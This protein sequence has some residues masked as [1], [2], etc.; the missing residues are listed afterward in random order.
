[1][2]KR[3]LNKQQQRRIQTGQQRFQEES[4]KGA[5]TGLIISRYGKS[6]EMEDAKGEVRICSIR[7]NL[8]SSLVAGDK[9]HWL[10]TDNDSGVI[11][12]CEPRTN[13]LVRY[14][15]F[16]KEKIVASNITQMLIMFS[17]LPEPSFFII[18]NYLLAAER[19]GMK[20][21]LILNK[22]DLPCETLVQSL[23]TIYTPLGYPIFFLSHAH[24]D[25]LVSVQAQLR[26]ETNVVVGQSGVGKSSF[27]SRILPEEIIATGEISNISKLGK[28][29]TSNARYYH[30]PCGGGLI[31]SP[32]VRDFLPGNL[33]KQ[34]VLQGFK[35]IAP[36]V[37]RCKFRDCDHIKN[38]GCAVVEALHT[39]D[40]HSQRYASFIKLL[41]ACP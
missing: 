25:S 22:V 12:S 3:R 39:L 2:S 19:L 34:S 18:D 27:I 5:Q 41:D 31:D 13:A 32:G 38:P 10:P 35:E 9:V 11:V 16:G 17:P 20:P 30:L 36:L 26:Q 8:S 24:K 23:E 29:T 14:N 33:S 37:Q 4:V 15:N 28:H 7:P 6:A 1:M 40:I 21:L